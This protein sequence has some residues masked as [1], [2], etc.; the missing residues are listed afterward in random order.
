MVSLED[1]LVE[2]PGRN[3]DRFA[4]EVFE[5][6]DVLVLLLDDDARH[7][8]PVGLG[9]GDELLA[10]VRL[11]DVEHDIEVLGLDGLD[12]LAPRRTADIFDLDAQPVGEQVHVVDRETTR[13]S[14][15]V[16]VKRRRV[17]LVVHPN[18]TVLLEPLLLIGCQRQSFVDHPEP[19]LLEC[20][21]V[22][23][24]DRSDRLVQQVA[25]HRPVV[26]NANSEPVDKGFAFGFSDDPQVGQRVLADQVVG[27]GDAGDD[28]VGITERHR[29]EGSEQ[30]L[31]QQEFSV[32]IVALDDLLVKEPGGNR[33]GLAGKV[34]DPPNGLIAPTGDDDRRVLDVGLGEGDE[35]RAILR[36]HDIEDDIEVFGPD[37]AQELVPR[38]SAD[39]FDPDADTIGE[40][41]HVIDREPGWP[42]APV[43]VERRPVQLVVNPDHR[44]FAHPVPFLRRQFQHQRRPR[45][46]QRVSGDDR[47]RVLSRDRR[48]GLV[49]NSA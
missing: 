28:S 32:G 34:V 33:D 30:V 8:T 6:A 49:E 27:A 3:G 29:L 42:L 38:R 12:E 4:G 45:C 48:Q 11:H 1:F 15:L 23:G 18:D 41:V 16:E 9:K 14:E 46:Q 40:Q 21:P 31:G 36:L 24:G 13:L 26:A 17:H 5:G 7:E 37:G 44:M 35:F 2:E 47:V 10:L 39:I 43:E 25:K 20:R 19:L 22:L